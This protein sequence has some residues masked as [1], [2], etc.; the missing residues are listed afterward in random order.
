MLLV[1]G[2]KN[3]TIDDIELRKTN[4]FSYSSYFFTRAFLENYNGRK[5]SS[6]EMLRIYNKIFHF[7]V[8]LVLLYLTVH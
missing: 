5:M 7:P 4:F 3:N 2:D 6:K 8:L 1:I